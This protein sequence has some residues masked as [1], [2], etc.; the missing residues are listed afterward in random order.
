MATEKKVLFTNKKEMSPVMTESMRALRTNIQFCGD[1]VHTILF[2]STFPDEGKS[3]VVLNLAESIGKSG[4]KVLVLDTDM[5]KS[6]IINENG[7]RMEGNRY[8]KIYGL[9]HYLSGQKALKGVV[10]HTDM[11]M[12]DIIFAGRSVPNPTEMLNKKYFTDLLEYGKAEYDYILVDCAPVTAAIDAVLVAHYCDGAIVVIEQGK[13]NSRYAAETK[14]QLTSS[15]VRLLG[16][17]LNKVKKK[18]TVYGDYYGGYYGKYYGSYDPR[19]T[20][21]K[22]KNT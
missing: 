14:K 13:V 15:G 4:Q 8:E 5:R 3:T 10:Y 16:A 9:S 18:K 12:V 21:E 6:V 17:I 11:E 22:E 1:D 2:T 19:K 20:Q 7:V